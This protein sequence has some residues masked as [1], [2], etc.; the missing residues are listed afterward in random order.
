[1]S[2]DVSELQ[3]SIDEQA[4]WRRVMSVVIP[5]SLVQ[6]EEQNAARQL[7]SRARLKGFRKG[8]VP[9]KVIENRF[10]GALRQEAL[11]KLIGS[12]YREA[13]AEKELRPISEGEIEDVQYAPQE[14]LSFAISFDVEPVLEVTRMS[15][16]VIERPAVSISEDQV[17]EVL[18]RIQEQNGVWQPLEAGKPVAKDLVSVTITRLDEEAEAAPVGREYELVIEEGGELVHH[19]VRPG[20]VFH[21]RPG[22]RHRMTA[23]PDGCDIIE[24]STPELDDVVRLEDRYGRS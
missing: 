17:E 5:A 11:D 12:A 4:S 18:G 19:A 24:V 13:L 3:I 2:I 8:R 9:T 21:V 22:T 16:F 15:G 14:D 7:A 10:G 20:M 6:A 1:M 23:G